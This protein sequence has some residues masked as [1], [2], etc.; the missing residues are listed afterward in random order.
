MGMNTTIWFDH[1]RPGPGRYNLRQEGNN[2]PKYTMA[3]HLK[4]IISTHVQ[5]PG[6]YKP[7]LHCTYAQVPAY[8]MQGPTKYDP[9]RMIPGVGTYNIGNKL[10]GIAYTLGKRFSHKP[11]LTP[12]PGL[13]SPQITTNTPMYTIGQHIEEYQFLT[14]GPGIYNIG[15]QNNIA[16]AFTMGQHS[17]RL[18][19]KLKDKCYHATIKQRPYHHSSNNVLTSNHAE[20]VEGSQPWTKSASP[21]LMIAPPSMKPRLSWTRLSTWDITAPLVPNPRPRPMTSSENILRRIHFKIGPT[22]N[23]HYNEYVCNTYRYMGYK[24]MRYG[25]VAKWG[26]SKSFIKSTYLNK[27]F[28][29]KGE[30]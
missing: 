24:A 13:Y 17:I 18:R 8:T 15:R 6:S 4:S 25:R 1:D 28:I 9:F 10:D 16:P 27:S 14:P 20:K 21:P 7:S 23:E 3:Q 5:G 22:Q 26:T 30:L 11:S 12:G 19:E 29:T 2:S